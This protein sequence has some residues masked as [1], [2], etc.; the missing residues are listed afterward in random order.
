VS[1][2]RKALWLW[3]WLAAVTSGLLCVA[4]FPPFDQSWLCWFALTPLIA[5]VWFSGQDSR[6]R[7]LRNLLLGYVAGVVF[8]TG[9][10]SWLSSLGTLFEN[11][12]LH[13]L[14]FLLSLY[15][16]IYFAFWS[17]FVGLI[18]PVEAAVS[19]ANEPEPPNKWDEM[20]AQAGKPPKAVTPRSPWLRSTSNLL[21]AFCA[22]S[23]WVTHEWIRGWLFTGFSWNNLGVALHANWPIIQIAEFTGVAGLSFAVAFANVIAVTT[24]RRLIIEAR[25]HKMRPHYDLTLTMSAVVGLIVY[26]WHASQTTQP[27]APVR[28]AAVQAN[29]PQPEKFDPQFMAKTFERFSRLSEIATKT[30]PPPDL[31]IWPESSMPGPVLEDDATNRFVMDLVRSTKTDLLLGSVDVQEPEAYNAA[32]LISPGA[33]DVQIYRKIHLVPFGEYI[34]LR[35]AFPLFAAAAGRWVP[36]DFTRGREFTV[37][38]IKNDAVRIAPLICFED[39]DGELTRKFVLNGANLLVNVTNDGWFLRSAESKIHVANAIF[40]CVET[41]RPMARAANTGVTC[42]VNE[43]GRIT[44]RL[45]DETG[46]TF[47]EGVLTGTVDVPTERSLTFYVRHGEFFSKLCACAMLL[48]IAFRTLQFLRQ[49][50]ASGIVEE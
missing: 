17:W 44:Q 16:A 47:T 26:G 10:F 14:P 40:R 49:K 6:K 9:A 35:Q 5:A 28:I 31:I 32:L 37:F 15:M 36:G 33:P 4:C 3:P 7:W 30:S 50:K 43:F 27:S 45:Q 38:K 23:A 12:L 25:T 48:A 1:N 13:G 24:S 18:K 22:A 8:F 11:F 41:R 29:V 21:L 34:P 46:S 42:F 39:T 19:A 20:L 2:W